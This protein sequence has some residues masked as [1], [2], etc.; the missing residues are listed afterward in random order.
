MKNLMKTKVIKKF[1]ITAITHENIEA[2]DIASA[3]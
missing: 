1:V 2:P 3:L